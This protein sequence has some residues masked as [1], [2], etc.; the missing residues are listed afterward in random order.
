MRPG[1]H[2][3]PEIRRALRRSLAVVAVLAGLIVF[4]V[5]WSRRGTPP[6]A[7]DPSPVVPAV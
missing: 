3:D 2:G 5:W 6:P 4:G 1:S 7:A